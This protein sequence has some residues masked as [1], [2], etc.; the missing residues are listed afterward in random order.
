VELQKNRVK[1]LIH[2]IILS[3]D[4]KSISN[5]DGLMQMK[6]DILHWHGIKPADPTCSLMSAKIQQPLHH[7]A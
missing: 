2:E 3:N 6:R 1:I 5:V 7:S 4:K